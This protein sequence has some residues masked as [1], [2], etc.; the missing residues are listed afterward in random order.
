MMKKP[1]HKKIHQDQRLPLLPKL[2]KMEQKDRRRAPLQEDLGRMTQLQ[3]ELR[4][5]APLQ[6]KLSGTQLK[7]NKYIYSPC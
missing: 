4:R 1:K 6:E 3:E 7:V 5:G 2:M